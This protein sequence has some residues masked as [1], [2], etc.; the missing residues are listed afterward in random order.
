MNFNRKQVIH[1]PD[2]SFVKWCDETFGVNR[3]VYNTIDSWFYEKGLTDILER[4]KHIL[5]F[6]KYAQTSGKEKKIKFGH[7][8][9]SISLA[10]YWRR[11]DQKGEKHVG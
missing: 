5:H 11:L 8:G 1:L 7:G 6:L 10:N 9:L 3:G 4:R 2:L